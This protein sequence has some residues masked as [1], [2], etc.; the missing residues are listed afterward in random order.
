M[1][2]SSCARR[3]G[4]GGR[5]AAQLG[6][7]ERISPQFTGLTTLLFP[8]FVEVHGLAT[9]ARSLKALALFTRYSSSEFAIRPFL[10]RDVAPTSPSRRRNRAEV[11]LGRG[12]FTESFS[13][14]GHDLNDYHTLFEDKLDLFAPGGCPTTT[15]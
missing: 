15:A 12:S 11:I 9:P 7:L 6:V 13:L 2:I 8:D 14:F 10:I 1:P 4:P 3:W 5:Y